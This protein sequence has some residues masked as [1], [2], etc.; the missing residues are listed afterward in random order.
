MLNVLDP[1]RLGVKT[2]GTAKECWDS[3]IAEHAKKTDMALSEAEVLLNSAKFDRNSDI[4]A[5]VA[6]LRMK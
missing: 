6:D 1:I 5:H 3:I 2:D 4:N